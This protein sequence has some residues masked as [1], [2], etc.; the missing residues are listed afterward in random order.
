MEWLDLLE[1]VIVALVVALVPLG[2]RFVNK[3]VAETETKVD[4]KVWRT[5]QDAVKAELDGRGVKQ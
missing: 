1:P 2:I 4:D 3:K 5:V